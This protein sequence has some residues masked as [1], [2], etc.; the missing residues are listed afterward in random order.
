[1]DKVRVFAC[2]A[3]AKKVNACKSCDRRQRYCSPACQ[4]EARR[5]SARRYRMSPRGR[6][7]NRIRQARHRAKRRVTH[8]SSTPRPAGNVG[9]Q[10]RQNTNRSSR[11]H[12]QGC[13]FCLR[14]PRS[15]AEWIT[16]EGDRLLGYLRG[17]AGRLA[18]RIP[19]PFHRDSCRL[20][21]DDLV[22][23]AIVLALSTSDSGHPV[24]ATFERICRSMHQF[25]KNHVANLTRKRVRR[26]N[27]FADLIP[28]IP[29][30]RSTPPPRRMGPA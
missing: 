10:R 7:T 28:S 26:N 18:K 2:H 3:C 22:H 27:V 20:A 6:E 4:S 12:V 14:K 17:V 23:D 8:R 25:L 16:N 19:E 21:V 24:S 9:R 29:P 15:L 5:K 1:M 11:N 30:T 13:H